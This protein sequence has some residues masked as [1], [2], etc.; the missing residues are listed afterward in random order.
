MNSLS[1]VLDTALPHWLG[2]MFSSHTANDPDAALRHFPNFFNA[3]LAQTDIQR[4]A[5]FQLRHQVYCEEL[6][7]EPRRPDQLEHDSFDG[8]SIH[9]YINHAP[10]NSLAGTVRLITAQ[11]TDELLPI[12][13]Y[14]S[15]TLTS[16]ALTPDNFPRH[17]VC[18]ISRLAVPASIR[19]R[20]TDKSKNGTSLSH[21]LSSLESKCCSIVAIALYLIATLMC[22]RTHRYHAYVMIEPALARIL[23]RIGIHFQQIGQT[24]EFNGKRA[25]YYLDM[26]TT[27]E[28]LKP[29]YLRLRDM[30]C[31]QLFPTEKAIPIRVKRPEWCLN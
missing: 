1:A 20:Q 17:Q 6:Q 18:E 25:P 16:H 14:F 9:C 15:Q 22:V 10:S 3:E 26:R 28:T 19:R 2:S 24:I 13:Q 11:H 5:I 30:L 31:E 23:K 21:I 4:Q 29:E 7:F 8:R 27:M 12:E